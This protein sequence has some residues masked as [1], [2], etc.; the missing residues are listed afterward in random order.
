MN[1]SVPAARREVE[2]VAPGPGSGRGALVLGL[3]ER[4]RAPFSR[5]PVH[6]RACGCHQLCA[7]HA[8]ADIRGSGR[9]A[10]RVV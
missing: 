8:T 5:V 3:C 9:R 1:G 10:G 7:R 6:R 2:R 4:D